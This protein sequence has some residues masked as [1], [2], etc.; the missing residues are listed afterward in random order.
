MAGTSLATGLT[1]QV[2]ADSPSIH[3]TW[4]HSEPDHI[5]EIRDL[6][7]EVTP[8]WMKLKAK[9]AEKEEDVEKLTTK[10]DQASAKSESLKANV[11]VL[12]ALISDEPDGV[13][14]VSTLAHVVARFDN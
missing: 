6:R 11:K 12:H 8:A 5:H 7:P 1:N 4:R 13:A 2:K 10:I 9:K 3:K 14:S